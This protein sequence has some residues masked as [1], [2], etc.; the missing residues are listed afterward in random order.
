MGHSPLR[1]P[2]F[3]YA[4][5]GLVI[6]QLVIYFLAPSSIITLSLSIPFLV[7]IPGFLITHLFLGRYGLEIVET[8][9]AAISISAVLALVSFLLTYLVQDG[10]SVSLAATALAGLSGLLSV[11]MIAKGPAET[12]EKGRAAPDQNMSRGGVRTWKER[13][14]KE[15]LLVVA[16]FLLIIIVIGASVGLL[17]QVKK[18]QY[19]EFY[20]LSNNGGAYNYTRNYSVGAEDSIVVGLANHEGKEINYTVEVWLVNYTYANQEVWVHQMFFVNGF[21]VTLDNVDVDLNEP[22]KAQFETK[23]PVNLTTSGPFF[24]F[25]IMF[26]GTADP[27]PEY[28]LDPNKD[29]STDVDVS[30]RIVECVNKELQYLRL[31]VNVY[32]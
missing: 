21:N 26:K 5:L 23:V 15:K 22:W 30:W 8:I 25:F 31:E 27:L 24:L 18:E 29:Y 16:S 28:P 20:I 19:T 6:I 9:I 2:M 12:I 11:I 17:M 7:I 13:T 3:L 4:V 1:H 14:K 10:G 32:P